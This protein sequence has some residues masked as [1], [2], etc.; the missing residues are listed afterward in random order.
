MLAAVKQVKSQALRVVIA[1]IEGDGQI[2][3][4]DV[5]IG[6]LGEVSKEDVTPSRYSIRGGNVLHIEDIVFE[7]LKEDAGLD[8]EGGLRRFELIFQLEQ[9]CGCAGNKIE[10]V[11]QAEPERGYG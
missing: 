6:W 8:L 9:I 3:G 10:G 5:G 2:C 7:V 1:R 11:D 4:G